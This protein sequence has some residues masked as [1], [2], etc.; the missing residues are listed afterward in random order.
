MGMASE[1]DPTEWGRKRKRDELIP[2]MTGKNTAPDELFK[3]IHCNCSGEYTSVRCSCRRYELPCT[4]TC[5]PCQVE[6]CDNPNN[7]PEVIKEEE[8]AEH[9]IQN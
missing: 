2:I 8:D 3:I 9:R 6:N 7:T 5:G 1:I 4:A